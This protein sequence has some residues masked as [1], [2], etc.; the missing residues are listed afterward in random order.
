[1]KR[2]L[3]GWWRSWW[4]RRVERHQRRRNWP[5]RFALMV[6]VVTMTVTVVAA[7]G[8]YRERSLVSVA[9]AI[10][11]ATPRLPVRADWS[12]D[13]RGLEVVPPSGHPVDCQQT[14]PA[15]AL[16]INH[17]D[18]N[19]TKPLLSKAAAL[20]WVELAWLGT[21]IDSKV[22]VAPGNASARRLSS[23]LEAVRRANRCTDRY[24]ALSGEDSS[25]RNGRQ[26]VLAAQHVMVRLM[27]DPDAR[28]RYVRQLGVLLASQPLADGLTLDL[29]AALPAAR[30]D[31]RS[32]TTS[33]GAANAMIDEDRR[34]VVSDGFSQLVCEIATV[35]HHQ[36]RQLHVVVPTREEDAFQ[37]EY[38][39]PYLIDDLQ[40]S[41][42]AD[43]VV[44][45]VTNHS[46][47]QGEPGPITPASWAVERLRFTGK[48]T[49]TDKLAVKVAA[50]AYDWTVDNKGK[51]LP[52]TVANQLTATQLASLLRTRRAV[53]VSQSADG[54]HYRYT[55]KGARHEVWYAL[56]ALAALHQLLKL[57]LLAG[58]VGNT[59]PVGMRLSLAALAAP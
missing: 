5:R 59:D 33:M 31:L 52:G 56:P 54:L 55:H 38:V 7:V 1:M 15:G 45:D 2:T 14:R 46:Y 28:L 35:A 10:D 19:A 12:V 49:G 39:L 48:R 24:V 17:Y 16:W 21:T 51:R 8:A 32:F 18:D 37:G 43:M 57:P 41:A 22:V 47:D 27:T 29:R 50:Y 9:D 34:S 53:L 40:L 13:L 26:R 11:P 3:S 36:R 25:I 6:M 58:G 30:K 42:C 23:A 20:Q 4:R 44:A